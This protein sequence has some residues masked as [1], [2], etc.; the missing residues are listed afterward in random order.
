MHCCEVTLDEKKKAWSF[1]P[2]SHFVFYGRKKKA[3]KV[4]NEV[5]E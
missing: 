5:M 1:F 4:W 3:I 2:A